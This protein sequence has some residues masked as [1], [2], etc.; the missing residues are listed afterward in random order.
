MARVT[1]TGSPARAAARRL[2]VGAASRSVRVVVGAFCVALI[3][4]ACSLREQPPSAEPA[5]P[6]TT[7]GEGAAAASG[8]GGEAPAAAPASTSLQL[9]TQ[10]SDILDS[11]GD[12]VQLK[13]V[14]WFGLDTPACAPQGLWSQSLDTVLDEIAGA[15]FTMLRLP[16]SN[17]CVETGSPSGIDTSANPDLQGVS[18]LELMDAVV[19]G[20]AE[21]DLRVVLVHQRAVGDEIQELW[22]T[23]SYPDE[24]WL[25][26]W[27]TVAQRYADHPAVVGADLH[28]EPH[29]PACWGCGEPAIDWHAAA[30][31]AGNAILEV[32]P[33]WLVM[34][35]GVQ[36]A[37]G[38]EASWW[39]SELSDVPTRPVELSTPGRLVYTAHDWPVS[40]AK[41]TWFS[42]PAYPANLP[43][44]WEAKWAF[45]TTQDVAPVVLSGFGSPYATEVD[46]QWLDTLVQFVGDRE[47]SF[48]Y[49]AW[50]AEPDSGNGL[51]QQD[52]TTPNPGPREAI[53][54]LLD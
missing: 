19:D 18:T 36:T 8:G 32:A 27:L 39:G 9:T 33:T 46:Q 10:G 48:S 11:A 43:A 5:P 42:D 37:Q 12:P 51:V 29:G 30:T 49:W 16:W 23:S 54:P 1:R 2:G 52:W 38:G 35:A 40:V 14:T 44:V 4:S 28:N 6:P 31:R 13:G 53:A 47:L 3:A 15:G 21:R 20:A 7:V 24:Q 41:Q 25:Q 50:N 22:Y 45:L 34:V 26:D 17:D